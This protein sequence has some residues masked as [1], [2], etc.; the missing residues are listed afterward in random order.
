MTD[1]VL[2]GTGS[3]SLVIAPKE[4]RL[5]VLDLVLERIAARVLEH[6]SRLVVM[7]GGAEGMD[8]CLARAAMRLQVRLWLALPNKG[9]ARHYWGRA[10]QLGRD[11]TAEFAVIADY[12]ERT[13]FVMEQV[14][15]TSAL[16]LDGLHANVWRNLFMVDGCRSFPGAD[17]FVVLGPVR[18]KSGTA[19]CV[20]ALQAAG[21]WR[22]DMVLNPAPADA[23]LPWAAADR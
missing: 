4:T 1:A 9:Y 12:A 5:R 3:R 14:H 2:A 23:Q 22:D 19:H 11:R 20:K 15:G 10:S 18:P 7:S 17:D 21:K 13:T 6:G 16:T 8:E